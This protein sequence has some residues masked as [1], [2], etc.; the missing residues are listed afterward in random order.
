MFKAAALSVIGIPVKE[1]KVV[2]AYQA[3][4][5]YREWY[6]ER[7]PGQVKMVEVFM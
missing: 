1:R 3:F 7:E 5:L 4:S 6:H 2:S